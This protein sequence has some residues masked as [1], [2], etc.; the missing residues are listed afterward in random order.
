MSDRCVF[1]DDHFLCGHEAH[2]RMEKTFPR[3]IL[4]FVGSRPA[5]LLLTPGTVCKDQSKPDPAATTTGWG[6]LAKD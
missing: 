3:A 1:E 4:P 6:A 5:C 2:R